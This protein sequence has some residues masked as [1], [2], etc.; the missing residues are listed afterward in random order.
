VYLVPQGQA[1]Q[2]LDLGAVPPDG[3]GIA[4]ESLQLEATQSFSVSMT[5]YNQAGESARSNQ[6]TVPASACD[7]AACDDGNPCTADDCLGLECS[8]MPAPEGAICGA[9]SVCSAGVCRVPECTSD[10]DC[11]DGDACNGP[12]TCA[13]FGC[14][15]GAAPSCAA[16]GP[17]QQGGCRADAGCWIANLADGSPCSDGDPATTGDQCTAGQCLGTPDIPCLEA[18]SDP[19]DLDGDGLGD[20][21]D[22]DVDGDAVMNAGD[23]C[24]VFSNPGQS[25]RDLNGIG[26]ACECGDQNGDG[27]VNSMD[28]VDMQRSILGFVQVSPLCDA[29]GDGLCTVSDIMAASQ[30]MFGR[31]AYCSRYPPPNP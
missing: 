18:G 14:A 22:G 10:A 15:G 6:I 9:G 23:N 2:V 3:D 28:L 26:D 7:P 11:S 4:R 13:G 1:S 24:S 19:Q 5:A 29:N 21:C 8:N 31:P 27:T 12:E 16:P 17:C 20:V 25:D 30:K